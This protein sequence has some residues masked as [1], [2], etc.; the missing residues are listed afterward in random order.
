MPLTYCLNVHPG[1]TWAENFATLQTTVLA[2]RDLVSPGKPF[3]LGMRLSAVAASQLYHP[4][5]LAELSA[6][7][8][9]EKL[10]VFTINGFPFGRF[11]GRGE[12]VGT[13]TFARGRFD[14]GVAAFGR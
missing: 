11:A 6:F 10:F 4:A 12:F 2:V 7:L 13:A 8:L 9:S 5:R 3:G 14:R 1:E